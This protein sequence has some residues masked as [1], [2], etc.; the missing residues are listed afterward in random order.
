MQ[1]MWRRKIVLIEIRNLGTIHTLGGMAMI[2]N[3]A[4]V[5]KFRHETLG[6]DAN[7]LQKL[8]IEISPFVVL[9]KAR[10]NINLYAFLI[11]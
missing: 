2:V 10:I 4:S 6:T 7:I 5:C 1:G 3:P 11:K 9:H 8:P